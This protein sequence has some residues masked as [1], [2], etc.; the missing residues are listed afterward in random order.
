MF[1]HSAVGTRHAYLKK[2]KH[3]RKTKKTKR[4]IIPYRAFK[5]LV[6]GMS[7]T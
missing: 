1:S 7:T 4:K 3:E 5:S 6:I 2:I